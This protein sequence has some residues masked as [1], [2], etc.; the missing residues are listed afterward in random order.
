MQMRKFGV[1][2]AMVALLF[3]G[4]VLAQT[5]VEKEQAE[6]KARSEESLQRLFKEV[7]GSKALYDKAKGYAVFATTKA[8][9]IVT[10]GGGSGITVDKTSGKTV[11]MKMGMGGVGLGI[12]AEKYDMII[13]FETAARLQTFIDGGWDS[14]AAVK[15]VAGKDSANLASGFIDG[16]IIYTI[17][18]KG[19][20]ASVDVSGTRFWVDE[21]LN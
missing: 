1:G 20:M 18:D 8:G 9:F 13:L 12:G 17:G 21:D 4:A 2:A 3:A 5:K 15:A 6:I 14:T 7:A 16:T 10:G 11:F 19:L